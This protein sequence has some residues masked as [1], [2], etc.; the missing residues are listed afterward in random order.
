VIAPQDHTR[1]F[2]TNKRFVTRWIARRVGSKF[3]KGD[4]CAR[5]LKEA[6][7]GLGDSDDELPALEL[8]EGDEP[9]SFEHPER[10]GDAPD[11]DTVMDD[12]DVE[13]GDECRAETEVEIDK[14]LERAMQN[15]LPAEKK[16]ELRRIGSKHADVS[17]TRLGADPAVDDKPVQ[18]AAGGGSVTVPGQGA[19]MSPAATDILGRHGEGT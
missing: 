3:P 16:A 18:N 9:P 10:H 8:E 12:D 13:I 5:G 6:L 15:R 19:T 11:E 7:A 17:R 14:M 2:D 4:N 1:K